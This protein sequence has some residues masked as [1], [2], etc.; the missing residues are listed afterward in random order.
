MVPSKARFS[1]RPCRLNFSSLIQTPCNASRFYAPQRDFDSWQPCLGVPGNSFVG[2]IKHV[3]VPLYP[4]P[5]STLRRRF[6]HLGRL[7]WLRTLPRFLN[8]IFPLLRPVRYLRPK[9][10]SSC[11]QGRDFRLDGGHRRPGHRTG[12]HGGALTASLT[13][14]GAER[15]VTVTCMPMAF[16]L[17]PYGSAT[18]PIP[19]TLPRP[20][21]VSGHAGTA[22]RLITVN[23]SL[24]RRRPYFHSCPLVFNAVRRV[25]LGP[26]YLRRPTRCSAL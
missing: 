8:S 23:I 6:L 13:A 20:R 7:R 22:S 3:L 25:R 12:H 24:I 11:N 17:H 21:S 9:T 5:R 19:L 1:T 4:R 15:T 16:Y 2:L 18:L 26:V 10:I 14:V